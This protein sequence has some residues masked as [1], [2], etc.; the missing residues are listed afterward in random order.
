MDFNTL[1]KY[2]YNDENIISKITTY[3]ETKSI[4]LQWPRSN[5]ILLNNQIFL[6]Y[7]ELSSQNIDHL[8]QWIIGKILTF[9]YH[10]IHMN[11]D[12]KIIEEIVHL[13]INTLKIYVLKYKNNHKILCEKNINLTELLYL[14]HYSR[15]FVDNEQIENILNRY[16]F[17]S[18]HRLHSILFDNM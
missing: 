16:N 13:F 15:L 7:K 9:Y 18:I 3:D 5:L 11:N 2:I 1:L 14:F 17:R 10:R 4:E 8:L 12:I 6:P